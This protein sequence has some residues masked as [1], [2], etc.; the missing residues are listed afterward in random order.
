M[1]SN[2]AVLPYSTSTIQNI[3][4]GGSSKRSKN[5]KAVDDEKKVPNVLVKPQ[6]DREPGELPGVSLQM[7]K[8][9][10]SNANLRGISVDDFLRLGFKNVAYTPKV[11]PEESTSA[12]VGNT[13]VHTLIDGEQIFNKM[14]EYLNSAE[15]SIQ[16][17]MFEFQNLS[18]DGHKWAING[19]ENVPG[20][21]EQQKILSILIDK[22]K[23]HPDMKIQVILDAHKWYISS[24]GKDKHY[25]NQDMIKYLKLNGIDVVPYPRSSQQGSAL[26]HVKML[27]VDGKKVIM[28]GMNWGTHSAANHDA[29]VAVE[30]LLSKKNSEVDNIIEQNFNA[31]WKFSWQRLG[32]T[33][34]VNGPLNKEEAKNYK[35]LKKEIKEEDV[36]YMKLVG[37][38]FNNPVD[39]NR[40]KNNALDIIKTNPVAKPKIDVLNTK[41]R[42][43]ANVGLS[44][45]ETT[46]ELLMNKIKTCSKVRGELFVLSDD[47][48][49]ENI[50]KRSNEGKLDAQFI[51]SS[52]ILEEFPYCRKAYNNL[53]KN[54]VP[55]R[56]YNADESVNQRL[57]SK[58]AVFDDNDLLIGSTNWSAM[59]LNQNLGKG[60]R[61]DYELD[62]AKI[63]EEISGY[64][65]DVKD[66][67]KEVGIP[68]MH[69]L[70]YKELL[71]RRK[72]LH[73]AINKLNKSDSASAVING[74]N[75]NFT[76]EQKS[77]LQTVHGY[78][79]IMQDSHNSKEKY[80]RG[81]NEC[82]INIS[83]PAL[84]KTFVRQFEKDW[85]YSESQY[86]IL[87]NKVLPMKKNDDKSLDLVG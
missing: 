37:D 76:K 55:I 66:S 32:E 28:G 3:S 52:D 35:G 65:K 47:E 34:F 61:S 29:C 83:S 21:K 82:A 62:S 78:Y 1:H 64:M 39:K 11:A 10:I 40:Y 45:T 38:L 7:R 9:I 36:E 81:N 26:Q 22:K 73:S 41:P 44:G 75:Y 57:H 19:A 77:A 48:L 4:F 53:L 72:A 50:V 18:V 84:A 33:N 2:F 6:K 8:Y 74:K 16:V 69:K 12:V 5:K 27:A 14:T 70:N 80:K 15:K 87:K 71:E 43:L 20:S 63:D 54:G 51:I 79:G 58:W 25:G 46:R 23:E 42:E 49:V 17:E 56:M 85:K 86:D 60:K 24:N 67:E 68:S 59:G 31:D 30:T 13:R